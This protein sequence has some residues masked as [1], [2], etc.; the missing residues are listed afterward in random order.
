MDKATLQRLYLD[1]KLSARQIA[2]RTGESEAKVV[3]WLDKYG[4]PKRSISEAIYRRS[5]QDGDPFQVKTDLTP[6]E[7]RLKAVGLTLWVTEGSLRDK[8][9]V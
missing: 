1:E 4:V 9:T 7:E 2:D 3:Y 5:N 8:Y 6:E